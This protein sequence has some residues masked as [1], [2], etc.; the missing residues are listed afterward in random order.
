MTGT[1]THAIELSSFSPG[2][3]KIPYAVAH[4]TTLLQQRGRSR[5]WDNHAPGTTQRGRSLYASSCRHTEVGRGFGRDLLTRFTT[6]RDQA[7]FELL[8]WRHGAMVLRLCLDVTHDEHVAEDA[9]QAVFL[10]LACKAGSIRNLKS[11]GAWLHR[12]AYRVALRARTRTLA[13][14]MNVDRSYDLSMLP[15]GVE[16]GD[17][18]TDRELRCLVN[19]EVERL[20][21]K[22]RCPIILCYFE[23]LA[24]DEAGR[25]L[26]WPKG[27]V[28][29]RLALARELLGKRLLRRGIG[30]PVAL[31]VLTAGTGMATGFPPSALVQTTLRNGLQIAAGAVLDSVVSPPVAILT[32][33]AVQDMFHRTM[34]AV[35]AMVL[36]LVL[37][38]SGVGFLADNRPSE[39]AESFPN[40]PA[41]PQDKK[42]DDPKALWTA[43]MRSI[44]NLQ[45]IAL[46]MRK[47][48]ENYNCFPPRAIYDKGGKPLLSWRVIMLPWLNEIELYKQFHLDEPWDGPNNKK[49][50]TKMPAVYRIPGIGGETTTFYQVFVG[51]TTM[52]ESGPGRR[53][54]QNGSRGVNIADT[55]DGTPN[56]ILAVEALTPVPWT[57][58]EDLT[59]EATGKLPALGGAFKDAIHAVFADT[60]VY[61]LYKS[62]PEADLRAAIT[63]DGGEFFAPST[64]CYEVPTATADEIKAEIKKLRSRI[65]A[66]RLDVHTLQQEVLD[67]RL[68]RTGAVGEAAAAIRNRMEQ[69]FLEQELAK[70]RREAMNSQSELKVLKDK[71]R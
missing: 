31:A 39:P 68:V 20:P 35:T 59:Y 16:P 54:G 58:P 40:R 15:A 47:Y 27:T 24:H 38:G 65:D 22:Y 43:R 64:L 28:A 30:L 26:G 44:E 56:T 50:L 63:R 67:L 34:T 62:A 2:C 14:G 71:H 25:K 51:G 32:Q 55:T 48:E 53:G 10:A 69:D 46:A 8:L 36:T 3:P 66:A 61:C 52:F 29:G 33:G 4:S 37:A 23:G 21:A 13:G 1:G 6:G 7:A 42:S 41:A 11:L 45:K 49:L 70:L 12:T 60:S 17:E 5:E 19:E 9:F 18:I 57:K